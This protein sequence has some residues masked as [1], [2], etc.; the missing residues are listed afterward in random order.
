MA[1]QLAEMKY[2]G[3]Q[4]DSTGKRQRRKELL[5]YTELFYS[6]LFDNSCLEFVIVHL[7]SVK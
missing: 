7:E 3:S 1:D 4:V 2:C 6:S 5:K